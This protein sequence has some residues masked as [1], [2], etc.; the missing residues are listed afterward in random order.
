MLSWSSAFSSTLLAP[1]PLDCGI[2]AASALP[3]SDRVVQPW[4][5]AAVSAMARLV[6]GAGKLVLAR[7]LP[8]V[9]PGGRRRA[10]PD[11][12]PVPESHVV[13][14]VRGR[15][16]RLRVVPRGVLVGLSV[17]HQRVVPRYTLPRTAARPRTPLQ[18][19]LADALG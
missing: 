6:P 2:D 5:F 16:R 10:L 19:F 15:R 9:E 11:V 4:S 7:L 1:V 8:R 13:L 18:E 17:H 12:N 3:R 14:D